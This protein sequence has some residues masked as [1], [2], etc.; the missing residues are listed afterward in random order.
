MPLCLCMVFHSSCEELS[1]NEVLDEKKMI[2]HST[3][4]GYDFAYVA[5]SRQNLVPDA[6]EL[7][8]RCFTQQVGAAT[9]VDFSFSGTL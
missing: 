2:L 8:D 6:Y 9:H 4:C 3:S 1:A 7:N 5:M